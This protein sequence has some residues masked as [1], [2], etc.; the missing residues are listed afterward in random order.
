MP[1]QK[2]RQRRTPRPWWLKLLAWVG[3]STLFAIF[4]DLVKSP[5]SRWQ[6]LTFG[7]LLGAAAFLLLSASSF[8]IRRRR[9]EKTLAMPNEPLEFEHILTKLQ[10]EKTRD[11]KAELSRLG[12]QLTWAWLLFGLSIATFI[13]ASPYLFS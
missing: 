7:L 3:S 1:D 5:E 10:S 11:D 6:S 9:L 2:L 13:V 8:G 4:Y 12:T